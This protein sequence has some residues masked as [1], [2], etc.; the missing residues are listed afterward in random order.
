MRGAHLRAW[1]S[2]TYENLTFGQVFVTL[3]CM[4]RIIK[5]SILIML[6]FFLLACYCH[7]QA[8]PPH[9]FKALNQVEAS[10][11]TG[12]ILGDKGGALG[13]LQ[14]RLSYWQDARMKRG[15]YKDCANYDY[16]V[17]V[18]T[19]YLQRYAP[20]AVRVKDYETLARVHNGGPRG[21][22]KASTTPYW[23]KVKK[24]LDKQTN[25]H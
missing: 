7:G 13:P 20:H 19:A 9:F 18:V 5:T 16:A 25:I 2:T 24:A 11:K 4:Y 21:A 17:E 14:I 15:V 6:A 3:G 10:G 8:L 23:K 1:E 22:E 12:P